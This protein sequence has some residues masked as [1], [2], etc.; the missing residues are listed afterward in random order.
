MAQTVQYILFLLLFIA[1]QLV[2]SKFSF[3]CNYDWQVMQMTWYT[4]F[5]I[6]LYNLQLCFSL[7]V[8]PR[9]VESTLWISW[10]WW[11]MI[12]M[13]CSSN[14]FTIIQ[15]PTWPVIPAFLQKKNHEL[16]ILLCS[17]FKLLLKANWLLSI[18]YRTTNNPNNAKLICWSDAGDS[19]FS[20]GIKQH[21]HL[22]QSWHCS[23]KQFEG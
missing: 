10:H 2:L 4:F 21:S 16:R 13:C 6:L 9:N 18:Y 8:L 11:L 17:C 3:Y 22:V 5:F 15:K 20:G 7:L 14:D 19:F 1:N 12:C 23:G